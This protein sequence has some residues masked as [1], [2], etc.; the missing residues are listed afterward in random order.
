MLQSADGVITNLFSIARHQARRRS[1]AKSVEGT[2]GFSGFVAST[3]API[4]T[5]WNE[6]VPGVGIEPR[7]A[8]FVIKQNHVSSGPGNWRA[9][10][11]S[12]PAMR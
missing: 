3:A 4:A 9:N 5:G 6:S 12:K 8:H 10:C 1:L 11:E 7:R 2:G